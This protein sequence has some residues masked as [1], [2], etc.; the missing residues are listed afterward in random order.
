MRIFKYQDQ[1]GEHTITDEEILD[2]YY[3]YWKEQMRKVDKENQISPE[4]CIEDFIVIHWA[5]E[6]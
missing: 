4:L 3:P 1:D 6:E 5:H 2:S